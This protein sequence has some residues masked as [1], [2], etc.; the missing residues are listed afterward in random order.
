MEYKKVNLKNSLKKLHELMKIIFDSPYPKEKIIARLK[1]KKY[2]IYVAEDNMKIVG[3]KIWYEES[4]RKIYSWLG[5]VHPNYRRQKIA[6]KLLQIQFE[7][8]KKE[9]YKVVELKTHE[10]H[11]E[12]IA[13]VE[14]EGFKKTKVKKDYW[15]Q[16]KDAIF[17]EKKV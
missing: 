17:Y 1:G 3:F 15:G 16:G 4:P 12:M 5:G 10:G 11:P 14:K 2:W 6:T 9:G 7:V 8:A 13:F